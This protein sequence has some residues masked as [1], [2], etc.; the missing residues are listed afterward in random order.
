VVS[1]HNIQ[2]QPDARFMS[3]KIAFTANTAWCLYNF[4]SAPILGL[5]RE[6]YSLSIYAPND[7]YT[8][9]LEEIGCTVTDLPIDSRGTN[10]FI[11]FKT[12]L[13]YLR[14]FRRD[15]PNLVFNYTIKSVIYGSMAAKWLGI[16]SIAVVSGLGYTFINSDWRSAVSK[17]L[18]HWALRYPNEIWFLNQ[19]DFGV[20]KEQ[21]LIKGRT[22][23]VLDGEGVDTEHF[24]PRLRQPAEGPVTFLMISRLYWDKGVREYVEAAAIVKQRFP[25]ARF[26]IL[27]PLGDVSPSA[28]TPAQ[29]KDWETKGWITHLGSTTDV[30][31][32]I[33]DSDCIVLPSYREGLSR[34][35]MEAASMARPIITTD[36][37]GCRE[38]VDHE[39]N[40]FLCRAMDAADLASQ[41]MRFLELPPE[42]RRDMG[43]AG[44]RKVLSRFD[45]RDVVRMYQQRVKA[46]LD[47]V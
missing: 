10:P 44:R 23:R 29:V 13:D 17:Q 45:V 25:D 20:F 24:A 22:V 3:K 39:V 8:P 34:S 14:L 4:R 7:V 9:K 36:V 46:L 32:Y 2:H 38:V 31:P 15:R 42:N 30:R 6:G 43:E 27:G 16:P 47:R 21:G 12:F 35:L 19:D 18:Y 37:V 40:G 11:D 5:I 28:V 33:A 26:H 41:M 1:R